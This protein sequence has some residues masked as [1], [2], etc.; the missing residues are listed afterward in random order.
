MLMN[1]LKF[2][3]KTVLTPIFK[4]YSL[5][6][7]ISVLIVL[8]FL[9]APKVIDFV[10]YTK[11]ILSY[12]YVWALTENENI[13]FIHAIV[14]GEPVYQLRNVNSF[15]YDVYPPFFHLISALFIKIFGFGIFIPRLISLVS[16]AFLILSLWMFFKKSKTFIENTLVTFLLLSASVAITL[17]S[18]YFVLARVDMTAYA[19]AF[20][21]LFFIWKIVYS[22]KKNHRYYLLAGVTAILAVFTK[23]SVFFP[24]IVIALLT[25]FVKNRKDW[26]RF[27][28]CLGIATGAFLA[29]LN[30][31]TKG[32]F[33]QNMLLS[34]EVYGKYLYSQDYAYILQAV[35]VKTYLAFNLG[36]IFLLILSLY[37][38]LILKKLP[39]FSLIAMVGIYLNFLLTGGNI[40]AEYNTLIPM[41]FGALL[42]MKEL[43]FLDNLKLK[44]LGKI[45]FILLFIYQL[46]I[47]KKFYYPFFTPTT[48]DGRN[49]KTLVEILKTSKSKNILGDRVDYAIML[50]NKKSVLEASTH[51]VA[52]EWPATRSYAHYVE[53]D[54]LNRIKNKEINLAI[55]TITR[56]GNENLM[57]HIESKGKII[58]VIRINYMDAS[59]LD[60]RIYKL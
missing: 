42:I 12:P 52:G 16:F 60:H 4:K 13:L 20:W 50:A 32:G 47:L 18:K 28:V 48:E 55:S 38:V 30:L 10:G 40:G 56:L 15:L 35:F 58:K 46:F 29:L 19:L 49:Q 2:K 21:S 39:A 23:Q 51:N 3:N 27:N 33:L 41:V 11:N 31:I 8:S 36:L 14:S 26:I 7:T 43:H 45:L 5:L 44:S 54:I 17:Y 25:L 6:F 37:N 34:Q 53:K 22:N 9:L 24:Y 57:R 1:L 59:G